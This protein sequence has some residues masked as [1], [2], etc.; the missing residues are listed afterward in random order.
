MEKRST[1]NVASPLVKIFVEAMVA[2]ALIPIVTRFVWMWN[3][4]GMIANHN[5]ITT[6]LCL[7]GGVCGFTTSYEIDR[8]FWNYN[9]DAVGEF[10]SVVPAICIVGFALLTYWG[11]TYVSS[12]IFE[13][14]KYH[15]E[16]LVSLSPWP[17]E[18]FT[19]H[20]RHEPYVS[21]DPQHEVAPDN[22]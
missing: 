3:P 9:T 22:K 1:F 17:F 8:T 14:I 10:Y 6:T 18:K 21:D 12:R 7:N 4:V 15:E 2:L 13:N 19:W 16:D 5:I 20:P 11:L